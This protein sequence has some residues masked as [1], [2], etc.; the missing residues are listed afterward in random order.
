MLGAISRQRAEAERLRV[1]VDEAAWTLEGVI[2]VTPLTAVGALG[3]ALASQS[4]TTGQVRLQHTDAGVFLFEVR[5]DGSVV[6]FGRRGPEPVLPA[7]TFAAGVP[8]SEPVHV[9]SAPPLSRRRGV[10]RPGGCVRCG[11]RLRVQAA[12]CGGCGMPV[13]VLV[14]AHRAAGVTSLA[15]AARFADSGMPTDQVPPVDAPRVLVARTHQLGLAAARRQLAEHRDSSQPM[16]LLLVPDA[17][18]RLP[19]PLADQVSI[20]AAASPVTRVP[21]VEAWRWAP[22][23][24]TETFTKFF[25]TLAGQLTADMPHDPSMKGQDA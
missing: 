13:P 25:P 16:R 1:L 15:A 24:P 22:G 2:G 18:G 9:A 14:G 8:I 12:R 23:T 10:L 17:P 7:G 5:P 11:D 19:K 20:I 6:M 4:S 3:V 21:W